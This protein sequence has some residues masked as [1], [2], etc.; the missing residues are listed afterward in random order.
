MSLGHLATA[1]TSVDEATMTLNHCSFSMLNVPEGGQQNSWQL[2]KETHSVLGK[3]EGH[4]LLIATNF[5]PNFAIITKDIS[6][7]SLERLFR[8]GVE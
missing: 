1:R 8:L 7:R 3:C 4:V 5:D 2:S 6:D